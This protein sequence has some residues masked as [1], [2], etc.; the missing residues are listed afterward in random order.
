MQCFKAME[1]SHSHKIVCYGAISRI[2]RYS[3]FC[4]RAKSHYKDE[5]IY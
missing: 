1:S 3:C 2:V 4:F 5:L